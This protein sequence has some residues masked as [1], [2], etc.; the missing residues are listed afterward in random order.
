MRTKLT[1]LGEPDLPLQAF[2][3][4]LGRIKVFGKADA[5]D[6]PNYEAAAN[7]T[8]QGNL[9][10]AQ[11]QMGANRP[12]VVNPGGYSTWSLRPGVDPNNAQPGDW[13][14]LNNLSPDQ[15]AIFDRGEQI[16]TGLADT[17]LKGIN[18]IQS[19]YNTPLTADGLPSRS[20]IALPGSAE[21]YAEDRRKIEDA[22]Y[23][24]ATRFMDQRFS[25]DEDALRT[26]LLNK[27]LGEGSAAYQAELEQFRRGKDEAYQGAQNQAI[28]AGGQ[29]QNR[30]LQNLTNEISVQDQRRSNAMDERAFLRQQPLNELNALMARQ[31]MPAPQGSAGFAL[32][33]QTQGPDYMSA[34]TNSYNA[35]ADATN[36]ENTQ[37]GQTASTV[38]SVAASL[39]AY[40]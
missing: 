39:I 35:A 11:W 7:A 30:I 23:N 29:E 3:P 6:P 14:Q 1:I 36:F 8:A 19:I 32:A 13:I 9:Q 17:T 40:Y 34:A 22:V 31:Q 33:G 5:P 24:R 28:L 12:T 38:G 21:A 10:M 27:G 37:R 4:V 20:N 15:Q 25:R 2:K 18:N 26:Q 16:Q